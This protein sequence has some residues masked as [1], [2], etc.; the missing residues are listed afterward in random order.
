MKARK[1]APVYVKDE[2]KFQDF[3]KKSYERENPEVI[4]ERERQTRELSLK[5]NI[6]EE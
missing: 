4:K 1:N 2:Q 3:T 5:D 6:E